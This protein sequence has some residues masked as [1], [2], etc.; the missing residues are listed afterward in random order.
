[1]ATSE[2][3]E[4]ILA[5]AAAIEGEAF[6]YDREQID[7]EM[8]KEKASIYEGLGIKILAIAGGFLACV[9]FLGFLAIAGLI[10]SK[11]GMLILGVMAI[12]GS[13]GL[14]YATNSR[15]LDGAAIALYTSGLALITFGMEWESGGIVL[16]FM[17]I[18]V[19][20]FFLMRNF[21]M[22]FF[23]V[24]L[25]FGSMLWYIGSHESVTLF[26]LYLLVASLS[27][28]IVSLSEPGL[29]SSG[30]MLNKR[31]PA[32]RTG[33]LFSFIVGLILTMRFDLFL[34][35]MQ[36]H[37]LGW[38]I[39]MISLLAVVHYILEGLE[40]ATGRRGLFFAC[41]VVVMVP[42]LYAPAV[43][44][45]LLILL[46]GVHTRYLTGFAAGILAFVYFISQ[47]YY[48]LQLTLL[49][50]SFILMA[51]GSLFLAAWYI[52]RKTLQRDEAI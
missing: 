8:E 18:A 1:M 23:S 39:V 22:I 36:P 48:D 21:L 13:L 27:Y 28:T 46:L 12:G 4:D 41:L 9:F 29:L 10:E 17:V 26:Y 42:F 11:G 35:N 25:F 45:A 43:P 50:K 15:M 6:H 40:I 33:L 44:G 2:R 20:S 37:W 38:C 19:A 47:F 32:L 31:F 14:N 5:Q 3:L 49:V 30:P 34:Y 24:L 51:S 52:I 7:V 16:G